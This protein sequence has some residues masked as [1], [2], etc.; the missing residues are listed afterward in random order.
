MAAASSMM[1]AALETPGQATNQYSGEGIQ[2]VVQGISSFHIT[3]T[4]ALVC[5]S[6]LIIISILFDKLGARLGI[7][8]SIFLFFCD[9]ILIGIS[10]GSS[11]D[12]S[13]PPTHCA[14]SSNTQVLTFMEIRPV[15]RFSSKNSNLQACSRCSYGVP[16]SE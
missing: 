15:H 11:L 2:G 5:L 16:R 14:I 6:L 7:P 12:A 3:F 1:L 13:A 4:A 8:G 9:H 10:S